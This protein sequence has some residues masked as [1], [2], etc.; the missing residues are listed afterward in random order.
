MSVNTPHNY[1]RYK[2]GQ[3]IF[4]FGRQLKCS[5]DMK[6]AHVCKVCKGK[7]RAQQSGELKWVLIF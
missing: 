6:L 1:Y 3:N 7:E 2:I 5:S 4:R